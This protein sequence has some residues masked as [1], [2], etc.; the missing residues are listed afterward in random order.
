M[1]AYEPSS[2]PSIE[3]WETDAAKHA[4]TSG[5]DVDACFS[6]VYLFSYSGLSRVLCL[7]FVV[8]FAYVLRFLRDKHQQ[9]QVLKQR[10]VD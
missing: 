2:S 3:L 4:S 8:L 7:F 5:S 6:S 1:V 9:C 10:R